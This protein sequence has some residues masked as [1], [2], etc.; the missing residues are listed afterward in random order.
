MVKDWKIE[1]YVEGFNSVMNKFAW[2]TGDAET[3]KEA[4]VRTLPKSLK[5]KMLVDRDY[6]GF[7]LQQLQ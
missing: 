6:Q 1:E 2:A 4:F 3:L 7:T 5:R